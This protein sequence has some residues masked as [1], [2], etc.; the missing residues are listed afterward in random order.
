MDSSHQAR[1]KSLRVF[2]RFGLTRSPRTPR[3]GT[4]RPSKTDFFETKQR[5]N[6]RGV[7]CQRNCHQAWQKFYV[8]RRFFQFGSKSLHYPLYIGTKTSWKTKHAT[9]H[10]PSV[11]SKAALS[12][13]FDLTLPNLPFPQ[14]T[15]EPMPWRAAAEIRTVVYDVWIFAAHDTKCFCT[16]Y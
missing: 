9:P 10:P 7:G 5:S 11:R 6:M 4:S 13:V 2:C 16:N 3:K 15:D 1:L 8:F 14:V 12:R